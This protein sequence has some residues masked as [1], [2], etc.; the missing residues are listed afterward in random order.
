M[1]KPPRSAALALAVAGAALI[2][3]CSAVSP[4]PAA[5]PVADNA[6]T[7]QAPSPAATPAV[8]AT[9]VRVAVIGDSLVAGYGLDAGLDWPSVLGRHSGADV[10]NLA[11]SGAGFATA[12]DCGT[13]FAGLVPRAAAATP[14][15]VLIQSSDND[16]WDDPDDITVQTSRT[17]ALLRDALPDATIVGLSTVVWDD[18]DEREEMD[19]TSTALRSAVTDV[20]GVFV[21]LGDPLQEKT[22]WVQDDQEH[23]TAAGQRALAR[24]VRRDLADVGVIL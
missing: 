23:P 22:A 2:A 14:D 19:L 4:S 1:I 18:A 15:I 13:D 12:G 8:A 17:V 3:G 20:G 7:G 5:S 9:P 21:D 6:P 24:A 16:F 11:C 10:L